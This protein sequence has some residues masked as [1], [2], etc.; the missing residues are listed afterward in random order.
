M[1]S[2]QHAESVLM[3]KA[4][5]P[6]KGKAAETT[7]HFGLAHAPGAQPI[8]LNGGAEGSRQLFATPNSQPQSWSAGRIGP[9]EHFTLAIARCLRK[10]PGS[11]AGYHEP[12]DHNHEWRH[13]IVG[14]VCHRVT[15]RGTGIS[16]SRDKA[17]G[18][19]GS[20]PER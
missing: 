18:T 9:G 3:R 12:A 6:S 14:E 4:R 8:L 13:N 15:P 10:S 7:T 5:S 2:L 11:D 19:P 20:G 16:Q 17:G 1:R